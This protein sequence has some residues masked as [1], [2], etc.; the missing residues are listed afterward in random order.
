MGVAQHA[1][2]SV[3]LSKTPHSL[4]ESTIHAPFSVNL[5]V[6]LEKRAIPKKAAS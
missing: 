1:G 6:S 2:S 4:P 3:F 5:G